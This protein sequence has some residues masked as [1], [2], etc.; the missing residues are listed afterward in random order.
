MLSLGFSDVLS[1]NNISR[2]FGGLLVTAEIS[3]I[4]VILSVFIG[5]IMGIIMNSKN[6]IIKAITSLYLEAVRIIPI[7]VWLFI[8]YFG[9]SSAF[10]INLNGEFVS[11]LVFT[12]WGVAEMGDIVRGAL[13][14]IPKHQ[15]E[16]SITLGLTK[17]Q[18]YMYI[19]IP[20]AVR[21]MIP[22][23]IN[24]STRIIKTT[25]LVI[26]VGVVEV[27]KVGQQ[28]IERSV[29]KDPMASFWI[30]GFIFI[31]YFMI[32]YPLSLAAKSLEK[33]W[34]C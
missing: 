21:R 18:M 34:S 30:Y 20:Q 7:L 29:L 6:K 28:I 8:V 2:L 11:I 19:L 12:L 32:C 25:P 16:A 10:N 1:S 15:E 24:L 13:I 3:I 5:I 27:V 23:A 31:L 9:M 26:L 4:A 22:G 17:L 33:K 14:S